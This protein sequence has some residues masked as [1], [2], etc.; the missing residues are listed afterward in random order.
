M[1]MASVLGAEIAKFMVIDNFT[2]TSVIPC[3]NDGWAVV[4]EQNAVT[5]DPWLLANDFHV[6]P[7][8]Q[9]PVLASTADSYYNQC[10]W[11]MLN[12]SKGM[13]TDPS[14]LGLLKLTCKCKSRFSGEHCQLNTMALARG[15]GGDGHSFR[16][17]LMLAVIPLVFS[18]LAALFSFVLKS[19]CCSSIGIDWTYCESLKRLK[20]WRCC[21]ATKQEDQRQHHRSHIDYNLDIRGEGT[22]CNENLSMPRYMSSE[23]EFDQQ[24]KESPPPTY[25]EAA[26]I[27]VVTKL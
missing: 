24:R 12:T 4:R 10:T 11:Y 14:R 3:C 20:L 21:L 9:A 8:D 13:T 26:P 19:C 15:N 17:F 7:M 23:V 16:I 5:V 2:H 25:E 18:F 27:A 22:A 6:Q 1:A